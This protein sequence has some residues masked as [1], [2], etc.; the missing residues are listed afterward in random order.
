VGSV[1]LTYWAAFC[2]Q[3]V[4]QQADMDRV[5]RLLEGA[6]EVSMGFLSIVVEW[7]RVVLS[8]SV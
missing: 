7:V 8:A 3:H 4:T 2:M 6:S 1:V 5:T